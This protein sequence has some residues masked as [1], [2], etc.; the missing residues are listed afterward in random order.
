M[1]RG[2]CNKC[3]GTVPRLSKWEGGA[4]QAFHL[5]TSAFLMA[6]CVLASNAATYNITTNG[7]VPS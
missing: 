4:R 1:L 3:V 2:V 5:G 6:G 7:L